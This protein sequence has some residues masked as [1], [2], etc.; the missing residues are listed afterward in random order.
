[1]KCKY[2]ESEMR[3]DDKN[4]L[5]FITIKHWDCDNCGVSAVEEIRHGEYNK[6][7]FKAPEYKGFPR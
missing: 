5:G 4:T 6:L 1:M 7:T 3:L 2:C